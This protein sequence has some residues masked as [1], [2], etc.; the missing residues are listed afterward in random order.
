MANN[1]LDKL[2]SNH[3]SFLGAQNNLNQPHQYFNQNSRVHLVPSANGPV[4]SNQS[5]HSPRLATEQTNNT[6]THG[7][8]SFVNQ[9]YNEYYFQTAQPA[10]NTYS[11]TLQN[12]HSGNT[13]MQTTANIEVRWQYMFHRFQHPKFGKKY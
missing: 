11:T 6:M 9:A 4:I 13:S 10:F 7:Q 8:P 2:S 5:I 12:S 3:F 1:H